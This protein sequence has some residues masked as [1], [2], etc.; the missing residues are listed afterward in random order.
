MLGVGGFRENLGMSSSLSTYAP[1][2]LQ[3]KFEHK[4]KEWIRSDGRGFLQCRPAFLRAGSGNAA[5]GSAFAEFGSTKV[6]V[7]IFGPRESKK[8]MTYSDIGR[9]NCSVSLT[10]FATPTRAKAMGW[11]QNEKTCR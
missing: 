6:I 11:E 1:K 9:L 4:E 7:S 2:K 5:A 8:A 3:R 10:S